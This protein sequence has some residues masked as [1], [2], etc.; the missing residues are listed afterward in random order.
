MIVLGLDGQI[1]KKPCSFI[2]EQLT[3]PEKVMSYHLLLILMVW[4]FLL[5]DE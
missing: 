1:R 5:T 2:L 4:I 3:K